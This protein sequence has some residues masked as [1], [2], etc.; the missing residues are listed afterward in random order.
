MRAVKATVAAAALLAASCSVGEG[1]GEVR[2]RLRVQACALDDARYSMQPT[3]FAGDWH[4]GT[5]TVRVGQ[6]G[7]TGD[8]SD[9]LVV[10]VDDTAFVAQHLNER[11]PVGPPGVTPVHVSLRLSKS[12]GHS[13]LVQRSPVVALQATRGYVVFEAIYRGDPGS[14]AAARRTAVSSFSVYLEDPRVVRDEDR[15]VSE[16]MVGEG[17]EPPVLGRS[18]AELEGRFEFYFARGRPAQR[19]Q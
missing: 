6:G 12:C 15:V 16:P 17:R 14:D 1:T 19:F 5:F 11:L 7:D 10:L 13:E 8:Y 4:Q 3:F 18:R 9:E 2:G